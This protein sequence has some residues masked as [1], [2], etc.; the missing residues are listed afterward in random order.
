MIENEDLYVRVS[1]TPR[2]A[3]TYSVSRG[4]LGKRSEKRMFTFR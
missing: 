3:I 1:C 4:L 2:E